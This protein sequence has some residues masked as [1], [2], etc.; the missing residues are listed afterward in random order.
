VIK[1]LEHLDKSMGNRTGVMSATGIGHRLAAT[2]L[3]VGVDQLNFGKSL[4]HSNGR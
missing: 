2:G 4:K 3:V 1:V